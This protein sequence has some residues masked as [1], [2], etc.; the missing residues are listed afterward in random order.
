MENG[1]QRQM[2][3]GGHWLLP[4]KFPLGWRQYTG[5]KEETSKKVNIHMGTYNIVTGIE[6]KEEP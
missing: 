4:H 3:K 2:G 1:H 6:K 5:K